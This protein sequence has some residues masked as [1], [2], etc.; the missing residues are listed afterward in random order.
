VHTLLPE[1]ENIKDKVV[2]VAAQELDEHEGLDEASLREHEEV[3]K[4]KNVKEVE[5]GK[6]NMVSNIACTYIVVSFNSYI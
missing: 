2:T 4:V 5:L 3:T 6:Y 1:Y